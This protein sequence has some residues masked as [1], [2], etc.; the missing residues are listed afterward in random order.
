[1]LI[2]PV[3]NVEFFILST[4]SSV[5]GVAVKYTLILVFIS[6]YIFAAEEDA[7]NPDLLRAFEKFQ[8]NPEV[9]VEQEC[10]DNGATEKRFKIDLID[11]KKITPDNY[12]VDGQYKITS[13]SFEVINN[14]KSKVLAYLFH[15]QNEISKPVSGM[16]IQLG[17]AGDEFKTYNPVSKK[18]ELLYPSRTIIYDYV[19]RG[20]ENL[21]Q[22]VDTPVKLLKPKNKKSPK[23]EMGEEAFTIT[24]FS[25]FPRVNV[26]A[27]KISGNQAHIILT[28]GE[29][30]IV[31]INSGKI[32][33]GVFL[34]EL[35]NEN[36]VKNNKGEFVFPKTSVNYKG[37]GLF[38][39]TSLTI[40][41][42][43]KAGEKEVEVQAFV[44][45]ES[46]SCKLSPSSIWQINQGSSKDGKWKCTKYVPETDEDFYNLIKN[47]C[48]EFKFPTLIKFEKSSEE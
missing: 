6:N 13:E 25:L 26:P 24:E 23:Y 44:D 11:Q 1:M 34:E 40:N 3:G 2:F 16:Q 4:I 5:M 22:F 37:N 41:K 18:N 14:S 43:E 28:T 12:C 35:Q 19:G 8:A 48:P 31:N 17:K 47:K 36:T 29:E 46:Q 39:K 10:E 21:L 38:I 42:N 27:L 30:L 7:V 15:E 20:K 33:S 32:E 9:K 45:G